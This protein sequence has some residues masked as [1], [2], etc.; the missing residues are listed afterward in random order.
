VITRRNLLHLSGV[1]AMTYALPTWAQNLASPDYRLEI[2]PITLDLSPRHQLKTMAYNGQVP[3]PLLR[4]K[5]DQPVTIEITNHTDRPEV[6][7]WHGLLQSH[8]DLGFMMIFE[9]A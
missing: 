4:L 3:G 7:H 9:Y 1:G 2:S 8:M 5:E 6:I